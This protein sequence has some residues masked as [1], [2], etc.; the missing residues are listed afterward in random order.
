MNVEHSAL[1]AILDPCWNTE[2]RISKSSFA[3]GSNGQPSRSSQ[4]YP[5]SGQLALRVQRVPCVSG[6]TRH[7]YNLHLQESTW[8]W[9]LI[10]QEVGRR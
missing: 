8:R 10:G 5:T 4:S 7:Q 1:A 6:G 2:Y 3:T 9:D